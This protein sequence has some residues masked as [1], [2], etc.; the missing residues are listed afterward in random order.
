MT[1]AVGAS[2][3]V[4]FLVS[5][6][7]DLVED[8]PHKRFRQAGVDVV[9]AAADGGP[10]MGLAELSDAEIAGFAGVFVPDNR[11]ALAGLTGNADAGRVLRILHERNAL[12]VSVGRGPAALLAAPPNSEGQWLFDGYRLTS[13]AGDEAEMPWRLDTAL[14][15][16]GAV[17][18]D[19]A[20]VVVDR[21]LVTARNTESAG[22][23]AGAALEL[24]AVKGHR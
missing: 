24:M 12:I 15:A 22:A 23:A 13:Y 19:I 17:F 16:A 4:L 20:T 7:F 1:K 11:G 2:A 6:A 18:E 10:L 14:K 8:L 21:N 9:T 3:R 5:S